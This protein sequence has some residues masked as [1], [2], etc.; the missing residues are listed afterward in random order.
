[1]DA[2]FYFKGF[3]LGL[4]IA[5]PVGPIGVL[6]IRRT[7]TAGR[8]VGLL[9][10]IGAATADAC[11]GSLAAFG[12]MVIAH[13]L[14]DQ[15]MWLQ[16]FGGLFLVFLAVRTWRSAGT[17][18]AAKPGKTNRLFGAYGSTFVLTR[19]NPMTI[20]S[21][22]SMFAG[23]GLTSGD[24]WQAFSIVLGVF[25]GSAFWWLLLSVCIGS[26]RE[27]MDRKAFI[28]VD[29]LSAVVIFGFAIVSLYH[30]FNKL[31]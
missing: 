1:M 8:L 24:P 3:L 23:I 25:S 14:L 26:F 28:W 4:A 6:C 5:A 18:D 22:I 9:S 27:K 30:V 17:A 16:T 7:L 12:L 19:T 31:L 15:Q 20:L 2:S 29:H 11:F 10:G 13:F 21:F